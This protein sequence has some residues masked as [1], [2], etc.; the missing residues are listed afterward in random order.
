MNNPHKQLTDAQQRGIVTR[1]WQR[2]R[3]VCW[4]RCSG[5]EAM[6]RK[7]MDGKGLT[8]SERSSLAIFASAKYFDKYESGIIMNR[9][10]E[11][12]ERCA[13]KVA[14]KFWSSLRGYAEGFSDSCMM[15]DAEKSARWAASYAA[16]QKHSRMSLFP[17]R[18]PLRGDALVV[19]C[20]EASDRAWQDEQDAVFG[21]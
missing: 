2:A 16:Y 17:F 1:A 21:A 15:Y 3:T 12:E 9:W 11:Y 14:E 5:G 18:M 6:L 20:K 13:I 10:H 7:V 8:E 4:T 19:A